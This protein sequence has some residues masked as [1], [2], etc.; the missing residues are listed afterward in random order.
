MRRSL[1]PAAALVAAMAGSF[2][3]A[4]MASAS[5]GIDANHP[6][7]RQELPLT[8][9]EFPN[10]GGETCPGIASDKDGWHF[11]LPGRKADFV[12]LKVTFEPG[13]T[14]VITDFSGFG[15]P[16]GKHAYVASEVGAELQKVEATITGGPLPGKDNKFP[17]SHTCPGE[18]GGTTGETST[19]GTIGETTTGGT[20]GETT[21]G[22]TTG[23][24][25][26]GGTTTGET[27]TGGT[28]TGETTTGGTT[29]GET[30]TGG[31]TTGET[32]TTGGT[33]TGETTTG[34]TTG[35]TTT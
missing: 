6:T 31:T 11:V 3:L 14:Q 10:E 16:E 8:A 4:P 29:T 21:T 13:G 33:T 34:G 27:T 28:T 15:N 32:T 18:T 26:T 19:G 23:E 12:E 25:T 20:T 7:L 9:A 22:G 1:L 17:L 35:G 24:T 5:E 2:A 30:T